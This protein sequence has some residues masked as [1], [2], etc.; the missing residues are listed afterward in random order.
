MRHLTK[1][2]FIC[3]SCELVSSNI[4]PDPS[5]YD[6]SYEIK[7]DRY[8]RTL[9][10]V[11]IQRLRHDCVIKNIFSSPKLRLN[12]LDFGC[13][14]GSFLKTFLTDP[15]IFPVGFD[16]NPYAMFCDV[17]VILD[18]YDILTFWDSIEHLRDPANIIKKINPDFVFVCTPSTDDFW[19]ADYKELPPP[20]DL[21]SWRH[22]M[23]VEHCHYFNQKSLTLFFKKIGYSVT[24]VN[25]DESAPR[26]G[27]GDKNIL[28]IVAEREDN[29]GTH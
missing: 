18:D 17:S 19:P 24:E 29:L 14:V 26:N 25:Y 28:T 5:I 10:G 13:G 23:P 12:L 11:E 27:G 7:Y 15:N 2:L 4:A 3:D 1:D 6:R 22:Y 9:S 20:R 21:T 16:I 8:E